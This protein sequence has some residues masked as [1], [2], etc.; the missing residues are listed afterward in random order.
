MYEENNSGTPK[1]RIA[2]VTAVALGQDRALIVDLDSPPYGAANLIPYVG[3]PASVTETG[4]EAGNKVLLFANALPASGAQLYTSAYTISVGGPLND[5]GFDSRQARLVV[6]GCIIKA[7]PV[8]STRV[9]S[10]TQG[11]VRRE[12]NGGM[13]WLRINAVTDV[14][15]GNNQGIMV[16]LNSAPGANRLLTP[17]AGN[18]SLT[19]NAGW[20]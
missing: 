2:A 20:Q 18:I 1:Y 8:G 13:V 17:Y 7:E 16:D 5:A 6:E 19:A 11:R 4:W 14:V 10:T 9:Y 12:S 3:N 15:P